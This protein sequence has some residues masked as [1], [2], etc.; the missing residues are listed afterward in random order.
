MKKENVIKSCYSILNNVT[1]LEFDCGK[2]CNGKCCKGDEKT[3]MLVFTGE[4]K[5]LDS[6]ISVAHNEDGTAVAVCDGSCNR[7]YRPLSCRIYPL[8]PLIKNENGRE[9]IDVI[10][11]PRADCPLCTGEFQ[12]TRQFTKAV[13]RV[14]KFLL[15]NEET[16]KC[17]REISNE[18]N[19]IIKLRELLFK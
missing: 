6:D 1:P 8:F 16:A 4:E 5:L 9:H 13:K 7:N 15:L 14:G 3:G 10:V 19:D 11:D 12:F 2:I 18:I 17:Y